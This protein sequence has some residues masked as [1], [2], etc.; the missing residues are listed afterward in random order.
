MTDTKTLTADL[1]ASHA[2]LFDALHD[3][4]ERAAPKPRNAVH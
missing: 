2:A 1:Q 4:V 3:L